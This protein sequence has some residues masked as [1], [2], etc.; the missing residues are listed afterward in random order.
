M[1]VVSVD[2][3]LKEKTIQGLTAGLTKAANNH[4]DRTRT[5]LREMGSTVG[6]LVPIGLL[7]GGLLVAVGLLGAAHIVSRGSATKGPLG[8]GPRPRV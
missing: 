7:G 2:I 4:G 8:S 1:V 5:G 6:L 3:G